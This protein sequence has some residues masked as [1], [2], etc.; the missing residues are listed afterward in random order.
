[1]A[2]ASRNKTPVDAPLPAATVIDIGVARPKA[3]EKEQKAIQKQLYHLQAQRFHSEEEA[4]A[5]LDR[6][7]R[8]WTYHQVHHT[9]CISHLH[10]AHKGR[11]TPDTPLKAIDW[12]LQVTVGA[13]P[14]KRRA[15][16]Q[17]KA[18]FV[19]GTS[20]DAEAVEDEEI[21][22]NYKGQGTAERG[23]R[24]LKE[25]LFFTASLFVKKPSRIQGLLMVMTLA[26]LVYSI[27][28]RRLRQ[29]LAQ[30]Q[31]TLPNQI[32]QPTATPTLRWIFQLLE[33]I[34]VVTVT[35]QRQVRVIIE[36]LTDVRKKI[37][38]LFGQN[39][40]QIYQIAST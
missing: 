26:L 24:F 5:S 14:E 12:Q 15:Q 33:G 29:Q 27:A 9:T 40:C 22:P 4:H 25:P 19:L 32:G 28:Q 23:F 31:E 8:K 2:S 11:P 21:L 17:R 20:I 37:L 13:D 3:Q 16:Q 38:R 34:N 35:L 30:Q 39:V 1:M 6:L 36:G 7:A 10:Y 18:C